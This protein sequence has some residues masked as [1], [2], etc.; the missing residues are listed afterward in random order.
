MIAY[1]PTWTSNQTGRELP[2]GKIILQIEVANHA[3]H[4]KDMG[5]EF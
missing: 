1:S 2:V 5:V 3:L 4:H